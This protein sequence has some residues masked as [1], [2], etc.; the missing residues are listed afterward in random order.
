MAPAYCRIPMVGA[1]AASIRSVS[2]VLRVFYPPNVPVATNSSQWCRRLWCKPHGPWTNCR[3]HRHEAALPQAQAP[4][5]KMP[6]RLLRALK[7]PHACNT[8]LSLMRLNIA[9]RL[10]WHH[11]CGFKIDS[12]HVYRMDQTTRGRPTALILL[13]VLCHCPARCSSGAGCAASRC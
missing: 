11:M 13:N 10:A 5:P 6:P 3:V 12:A 4:F 9:W 1:H 2:E 8:K 7:L